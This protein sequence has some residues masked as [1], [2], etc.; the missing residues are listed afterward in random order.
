VSAATIEEVGPFDPAGLRGGEHVTGK[1]IIS[2]RPMS[3][4]AWIKASGATVID[5]TPEK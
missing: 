5:V 1:H 2:D 3:E 4:E